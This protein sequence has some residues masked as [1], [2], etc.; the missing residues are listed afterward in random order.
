MSL[1]TRTGIDT[2][3][4]HASPTPNPFHK[5]PYVS[6]G[7]IH[8]LAHGGFAVVV[9]GST[10]CGDFAVG[11]STKVTIEGKPAHRL[12]DATSGHGSWS[13]NASSS[14]TPKVIV[15]G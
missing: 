4:G 13:P 15:G 10:A 11:G 6:A 1:L 3:I 5:T 7:Q 12:G 8:V 2:H 14:G 9:G